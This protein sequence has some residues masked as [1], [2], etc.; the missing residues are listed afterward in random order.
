MSEELDLDD[1]PDFLK[2]DDEVVEELKPTQE[3]DSS[4]NLDEQQYEVVITRT[5]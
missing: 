5:Y 4:L 2:D 3:P 1:T